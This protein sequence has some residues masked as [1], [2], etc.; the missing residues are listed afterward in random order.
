MRPLSSV[1]AAVLVLVLWAGPS[2]AIRA[3]QTVAAADRSVVR[4]IVKAGKRTGAGSGFVVGAGGVVATN[5]HVVEDGE[6][7]TVLTKGSGG[8]PKRHPATVLWTSADF[9]LALLSVP[10]LAA[11]AIPLA[12]PLPAKGSQV[13][14]IGYPGSA[15]VLVGDMETLAESTITQGIIGRVIEAS[16]R[17]GGSKLK[18]LQHAAAVNSGNSGGPLVDMCGRVIGVNTGKPLGEV[19][20][21]RED[22]WRVNQTDGI[23]F[24]SHVGVLI[25]ALRSQN[26]TARVESSD[27]VPANGASV[28]VPEPKAP[29]TS[30]LLV[31]G[32]GAAVLIAIAALFLA[33]RRVAPVRDALTRLQGRSGQVASTAD[34]AAAATTWTFTGRD[35]KNRSVN[36]A[37]RISDLQRAPVVIGR[38][39]AGAQLVLEDSSVSREHARLSYSAGRV[40]ICDL[41]STNGSALDG[42]S[43]TNVPVTLRRGQTL[44][45]GD[46]LLKVDRLTT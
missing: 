12:E 30:P 5:F 36:W 8:A 23:Y 46:V 27:C 2:S 39:T 32:I 45:L 29:P 11:E 3:D 21:D 28:V 1:V 18:I 16:W 9:D 17:K 20:G 24:A 6:R 31:A 13:A 42:V 38:R 41:G 35:G 37:V 26:V 40:Q 15:D 43:L 4:V 14:A 7:F 34:A 44:S 25:A 10:G 19:E 22:G 33:S